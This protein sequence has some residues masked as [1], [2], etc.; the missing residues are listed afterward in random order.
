MQ[1]GLRIPS[2]DEANQVRNTK[3]MFSTL[4]VPGSASRRAP[5]TNAQLT[6]RARERA[7]DEP[8]ATNAKS[9]TGSSPATA[10]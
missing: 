2:V 5:K 8:G 1:S 6:L 3:W 7:R 10:D 4:R 9:G